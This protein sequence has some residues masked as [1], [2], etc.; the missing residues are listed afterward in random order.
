M[1]EAMIVEAVRTPFGRR[2]GRLSQIHPVMLGALVMRELV[3]RTGTA[4]DLIEDV[5]WGCVGQV[6]EQSLNVG[7]NSWLAAGFPVETPAMT[8]DRQCGSSQQALHAAANLIQ[9][10]VAEITLAGG[11]ESMSRVPLGAN[12][13]NGPGLPFPP[14]LT[15]LYQLVPQGI[16]AELVA[17][18]Y[19]I[20]RQQMDEYSVHSH[21]LAARASEQGWL[22]SQILPIQLG[23]GSTLE[24]D[25]GIRGEP[26]LARM[27]TLPP[28]F[29]AEHSIT[30]ANSSQISDGAA[31]LLLMSVD[32]AK[33][34]G[35]RPRARIVAQKVVGCDPVLMLE[36]PIPGTR[37][38]LKEAG[39]GLSDIDLFEINEAF[40]SVVLAWQQETGADLARTNVNGGAIAIGHPLGASGAR[41]MCHLLYELERRDLRYGLQ[42]M[43]CGGGLGTATIIDRQI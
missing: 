37:A 19:G 22:R 18:K 31:G 41:L 27:A 1:R 35:L 20:S 9:S 7:R 23:D 16:S 42:A 12:V 30:A 21:Q 14:E 5:I 17:R 15:E 4:A 39:L 40:A 29:D 25:E 8:I 10:G 33:E 2:G 24:R 34:L 11:V 26:N 3:Q 13:A 38:V 36:G 28:A 43:C 6:G 32:K